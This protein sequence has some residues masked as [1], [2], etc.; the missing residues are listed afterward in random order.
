MR[1][2]TTTKGDVAEGSLLFQQRPVLPEHPRSESR[3]LEIFNIGAKAIGER[4]GSAS[5][6]S[7]GPPLNLGCRHQTQALGDLAGCS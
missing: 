7:W 6:C 2:L 1:P 5:T 4:P 3:R